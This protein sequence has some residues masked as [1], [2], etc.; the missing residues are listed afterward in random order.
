MEATRRFFLARWLG[1]AGLYV[2][3][4]ILGFGFTMRALFRRGRGTHTN[5]VGARGSIRIVDQPLLPE[6]DFFE[7]GKVYPLTIRHATALQT[8]EGCKNLRSIALKFS[9]ESFDSQLDLIMNTG[10]VA[11]FWKIPSFIVGVI[12]AAFKKPRRWGYQHLFPLA[13][14]NVIIGTR[15]APET[16]R[17]MN[18]Y[19]QLSFGFHAKDGVERLCRFRVIPH[20]RGPET[21]LPDETDKRFPWRDNR[22]PEEPKCKDHLIREY[23]N[24]IRDGITPRYW[25]QMQVHELK[26]EDDNQIYSIAHAWE[27][28]THPWFDVGEIE[29]KETLEPNATESLR[30]WV[31]NQPPELSVPDAEGPLDYR[32][33]GWMRARAYP[34]FQGWRNFWSRF[35]TRLAYGRHIQWDKPRLKLWKS[36]RNISTQTY[37]LPLAEAAVPKVRQYFEDTGKDWYKA[38]EAI[39]S[40]HYLRMFILDVSNLPHLAI[41]TVFDGEMR[42]HLDD[43]LRTEGGLFGELLV[44][45]GSPEGK[46]HQHREYMIRYARPISTYYIGGTHHSK[47]SIQSEQRLRARLHELLDENETELRSQSC[48]AIRLF[49]RRAIEDA[50]D[51][52]L[53]EGPRGRLSLP[54]RLQKLRDLLMALVNPA[55]GLLAKDVFEWAGR[56]ESSPLKWLMYMGLALWYVY[57]WLPTKLLLL[58]IRWM[59]GREPVS[60][61]AEVDPKW[62]SDLEDAENLRLQNNLTM[63]APVK[64]GGLRRWL[65]RLLLA[66]ADKGT[67]HIWNEGR[68]TGIDTIHFARFMTLDSDRWMLFMSDYDGSWDRYLGDFLTVGS[69]AVVPLWSNLDG[70]PPTRWLFNPTPGFGEKFKAFT[71]SRQIRPALWF[72]AYPDLSMPNIISNGKLRDGLFEKSLTEKKAAEWLEYLNG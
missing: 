17:Q 62:L 66:G 57:T 43:L 56:K 41:N 2:G 60:E 14:V 23:V 30:F 20:D 16:Y 5:G 31:K 21:G 6:S 67:R 61:K 25:L 38:L 27:P 4:W 64:P 18:Y 72:S 47:T 39:E 68:L 58:L 24:G 34:W 29:I 53:P 69:R 19:S 55:S 40:L 12:G 42:D 70:C 71:R 59:E 63:Y 22:R 44:L 26:P 1:K 36:Y 49:L 37:L 15:R 45:A 48:E 28:K 51:P 50:G 54:A 32:C 35:R 11:P 8:D 46:L 7:A 3:M 10:S 13:R 9:H 65:I 33:I 52:A